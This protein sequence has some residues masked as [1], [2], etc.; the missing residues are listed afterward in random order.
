MRKSWGYTRGGGGAEGKEEVGNEDKG[1]GRGKVAP[2]PLLS[3]LNC[4]CVG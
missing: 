4:L 1:Q 2:E 3:T